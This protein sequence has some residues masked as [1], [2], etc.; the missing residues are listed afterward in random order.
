MDPFGF[1]N[2]SILLNSAADGGNL[3][4]SIGS[5]LFFSRFVALITVRGVYPS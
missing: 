1:T 2:E 4:H 3:F 5:Y